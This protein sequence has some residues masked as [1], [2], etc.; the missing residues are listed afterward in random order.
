MCI[1]DSAR[2]IDHFLKAFPEPQQLIEA[3]EADL[4]S[5]LASLKQRMPLRG[6][7]AFLLLPRIERLL[8]MKDQLLTNSN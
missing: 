4:L 6:K 8:E 7:Y 5:Y 2:A 1:R 3:N